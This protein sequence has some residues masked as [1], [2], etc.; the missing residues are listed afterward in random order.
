[1]TTLDKRGVRR[2]TNTVDTTRSGRRPFVVLLEVGGRLIRIKPKG[3]RK[4]YSVDYKSVY[5]LAVKIRA[6]EIA[7]ERKAA[8]KARREGRQS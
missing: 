4:W 1:M 6:A 7:E 5:I 2:E 8:R 3:T